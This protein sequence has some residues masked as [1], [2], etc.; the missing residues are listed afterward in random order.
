M[1]SLYEE[2]RPTKLS[3]MVGQESAVRKIR[4][5]AKRGFG[6]KAFW[7]NGSSGTGKTTIARI[8]ANR[9]A[10]ELFINE[11]DSA[12][13][14]DTKEIEIINEN[15]NY[16]APGKGG[17]VFIIN[18]SHGLKSW[19]IRRLLGMLERIPKHVTFIFTTTKAGQKD[20]FDDKIDSSP[21]LSRCICIEL[22]NSGYVKMA[23]AKHCKKIAQKEK[24]DGKPLES[25]KKL[26]EK[27]Q[28]NFRAMLQSIESGDML[29]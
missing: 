13:S 16:C 4:A 8:I 6:G 21:L 25:Y 18:E 26:A 3:N 5:I 11:Y 1:A 7:I 17:R 9:M 22:A 10:D 15:M 2:Y 14:L 20:L 29:K 28:N 12:D 27:C 19:I 23:F 24:L